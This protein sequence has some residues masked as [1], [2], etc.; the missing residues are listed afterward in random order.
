MITPNLNDG[1]S[2][3]EG[4][5]EETARKLYEAAE[6]AGIDNAKISTTSHGYVVPSELIGKLRDVDEQEIEQD[7]PNGVNVAKED[8][9][10]ITADGPVDADEERKAIAREAEANEAD[11]DDSDGAFDPADHTVAEVKEYLAT[12]DEAE[13]KRVLAAEEASDKPRAGVQKLADEDEGDK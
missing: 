1:E 13:R 5:S 10:H 11:A 4:R 8:A 9:T 2:Y 7:A 12:A 3:V 6:K